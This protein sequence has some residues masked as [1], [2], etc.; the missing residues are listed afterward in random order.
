MT[1]S[2]LGIYTMTASRQGIDD[3]I[4]TGGGG[5]VLLQCQN[6]KILSQWLNL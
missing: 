5:G 1:T 6:R 3:S 4:W 2:V